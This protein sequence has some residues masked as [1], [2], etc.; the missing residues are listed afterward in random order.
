MKGMHK[1]GSL[2]RAR[3]RRYSAG[4]SGRSLLYGDEGEFE[5][6]DLGFSVA[7][8]EEGSQRKVIVERLET[9]KARNPVF[10]WC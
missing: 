3:G 7:E 5:D 4:P 8:D 2:G 9:V 10:S 1:N 6:G